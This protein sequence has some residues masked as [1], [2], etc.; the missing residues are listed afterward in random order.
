M[1][2]LVAL[3]TMNGL[4][5]GCDSLA[6]HNQR[7]VDPSKLLTVVNM[8]DFDLDEP[9]ISF[10]ELI[11]ES[12]LVPI[13]H[14]TQEEKMVSL[15]PMDVGVMFTGIAAIGNRTVQSMV[16]E[17]K[18][19]DSNPIRVLE[20]RMS[21]GGG[22]WTIEWI[23]NWLRDRIGQHYS[24]QYQD[25]P[26]SIRPALEIMVGGYDPHGTVPCV[27][28][29]DVRE[30][31]VE[32]DHAFTVHLGAQ[33]TEIQRLLFGIDDENEGVLNTQAEELLRAYRADIETALKSAG[34]SI[35][36]VELPD[37]TNYEVN[38][39]L[40]DGWGLKGLRAPWGQFSVQNA[41]DCVDFL[42][43]IMIRSHQFKLEMP[44]VGGPAQIGVIQKGRGFK[45]VSERVW[46]HGGTVT[47][48]EES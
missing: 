36:N 27:A 20:Y 17:L 30:Q 14:I 4:V 46:R 25:L 34:I 5:M 29:V 10:G 8:D 1:T 11:A 33:S 44:T 45:Y 28:R 9:L 40:S 21:E 7:L 43:N 3:N 47:P 24:E 39:V 19:R 32:V 48:I 18:I 15:A 35:E 41:I 31:E 37:P 22:Q 13:N 38:Q 2:T 6:T 23:A 12:T 16:E 26:E 42:V